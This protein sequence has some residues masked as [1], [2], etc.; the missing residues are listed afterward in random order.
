VPA[1]SDVDTVAAKDALAPHLAALEAAGVRLVGI[2]VGNEFNTSA[3]FLDYRISTTTTI[4]KERR[5]PPA[6]GTTFWQ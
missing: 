1:L 3:V 5:L 2:E 4:Q 6:S